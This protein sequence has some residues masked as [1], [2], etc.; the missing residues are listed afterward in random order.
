MSSSPVRALDATGVERYSRQLLIREIGEA[1][2]LRLA[3]ANVVVVGCGGLGVPAALYL[4]AA[5]VGRLLL[6][7]PDRLALDNLNRQ[8]AY[9]TGEIGR[10]KA[11]LLATQLR[12]L[13]PSI[14]VRSKE[15][16]VTAPGIARLFRDA[17]LVLECSD[18]PLTKFLINDYC[19]GAGIELVIGGA[20]GLTGQVVAVPVGGACYRCL[21]VAP[22]S[23]P[24][25][26]CREA[27]VLGPLVGM[28]GALQALEAIR[29]ICRVGNDSGGRLLDFDAATV[30]WREVR[31]PL[32]PACTAHGGRPLGNGH[33]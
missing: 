19:V 3:E 8:V 6:I 16:L 31:F 32:D 25:T 27:G 14:E 20:V 28:I 26:T 10:P 7:D 17:D 9:R 4:G 18:D 13:N 12:D 2:Q 24:G 11:E 30:R 1:G 21:F 15:E 29:M 5:G 23:D 33:N 22:P